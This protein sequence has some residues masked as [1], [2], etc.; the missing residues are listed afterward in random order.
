MLDQGCI[1]LKESSETVCDTYINKTKQNLNHFYINT[2][3]TNSEIHPAIRKAE[4]V[5]TNPTTFSNLMV[6]IRIK[7]P[8]RAAYQDSRYELAFGVRSYNG[9]ALAQIFSKDIGLSFDMRNHQ[10]VTINVKSLPLAPGS[11]VASLWLG[12]GHEPIHWIPEAFTFE[13]QP[14]VSDLGYT[15]QRGF[16]I[17]LQGE[18]TSSDDTLL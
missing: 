7:A 10:L 9:D 14:Q 4:I 13:V 6:K 3:Y 1:T 17:L 16:P 18:W 12:R 8:Q 11:Y 5:T 2:A 15:E